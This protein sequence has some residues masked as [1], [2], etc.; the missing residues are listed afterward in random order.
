MKKRIVMIR[1]STIVVIIICVFL[2]PR[3]LVTTKLINSININNPIVKI[4]LPAIGA[5]FSIGL[6]KS[7][8]KS[9]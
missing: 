9:Q 3:F 7:F 4:L 5:L 6:W 2:I 8:Q 1:I